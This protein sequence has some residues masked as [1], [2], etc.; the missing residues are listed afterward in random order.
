M[1]GEPGAGKTMLMVRVVLDLLGRRASG[2]PVPVLASL[3]SW[4]PSCQD[5]QHWLADQLITDYPAL[6][7]AAP[8]GTEG[9]TCAVLSWPQG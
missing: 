5:L 6:G 9:G 4:D 7:A 8:A 3:P 1:L 2:S